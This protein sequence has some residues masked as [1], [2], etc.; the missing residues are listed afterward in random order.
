MPT[1][2]GHR[3]RDGKDHV[4]L[5]LERVQRPNHGRQNAFPE[6]F[7]IGFTTQ[8]EFSDQIPKSSLGKRDAGKTLLGMQRF[9]FKRCGITKL[10]IKLGD[11]SIFQDGPL[12]WGSKASTPEEKRMEMRANRRLF[13]MQMDYWGCKGNPMHHNSCVRCVE[14]LPF[15]QKWS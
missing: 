2:S 6:K 15:G 11:M 10:D 13:E 8:T 9:R 14:D 5:H 3:L 4:S 12:E 7:F 1:G